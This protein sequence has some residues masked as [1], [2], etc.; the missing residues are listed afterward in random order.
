MLATRLRFHSVGPW[1]HNDPGWKLK[2]WKWLN[3][4]GYQC[5][6]SQ[7]RLIISNTAAFVL[8]SAEKMLEEKKEAKNIPDWLEKAHLTHGCSS[9]WISLSTNCCWQ[10]AQLARELSGLFSW[11]KSAHTTTSEDGGVTPGTW[12]ETQT[13]SDRSLCEYF[14]E[15]FHILVNTEVI[16]ER[17]TDTVLVSFILRQVWINCVLWWVNKTVKLCNFNS[18]LKMGVKL[19]VVVLLSNNWFLFCQ[20]PKCVINSIK[21]EYGLHWQRGK[22]KTHWEEKI[23]NQ[24]RNKERDKRVREEGG[25]HKEWKWGG[26]QIKC[27]K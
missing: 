1:H 10:V 26:E 16:M 4:E 3:R 2:Y 20:I 18:E 21:V 7:W 5:Q 19:R 11:W 17:Q 25:G 15:Y 22:V 14:R 8:N 6:H 24:S 13:G 12:L 23:N 9:L 27:Q